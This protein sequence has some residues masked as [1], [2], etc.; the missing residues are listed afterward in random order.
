MCCA[1]R[2]QQLLLLSPPPPPQVQAVL[3][4]TPHIGSLTGCWVGYFIQSAE[5]RP[6]SSSCTA[7]NGSGYKLAGQV[8]R[9]TAQP[10]R[11]LIWANQLEAVRHPVQS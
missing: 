8:G 10:Y 5:A 1:T 4:I 3:L 11:D 6:S 9:A 2:S 7:S